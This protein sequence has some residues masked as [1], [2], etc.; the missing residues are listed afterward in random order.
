ML[1]AARAYGEAIQVAC[2]TREIAVAGAAPKEVFV[3]SAHG[4]PPREATA[5]LPRL[6]VPVGRWSGGRVADTGGA[7]EEIGLLL[8]HSA[9]PMH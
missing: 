8:S 4:G 6:M 3:A 5:M 9:R 2:G 1:A 7:F